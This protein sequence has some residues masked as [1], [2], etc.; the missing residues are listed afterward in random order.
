MKPTLYSKFA[1]FSTETLF[2]TKNVEIGI[3]GVNIGAALLQAGQRP[4]M[5]QI[6]QRFCAPV[7]ARVLVGRGV[8]REIGGDQGRVRG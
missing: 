3:P 8:G 1:G 2:N 5:Q 7:P 6:L 4:N